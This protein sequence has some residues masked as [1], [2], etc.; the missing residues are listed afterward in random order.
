MT[1]QYLR[2]LSALMS[3]YIQANRTYDQ[4]SELRIWLGFT[5]KVKD[6]WVTVRP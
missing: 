5:V 2:P 3:T 4:G 1:G 6:I